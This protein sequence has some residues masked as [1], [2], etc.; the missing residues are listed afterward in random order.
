M[1]GSGLD[2]LSNL[3]NQGML[4]IIASILKDIWGRRA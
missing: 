1:K 4:G 2:C 3:E